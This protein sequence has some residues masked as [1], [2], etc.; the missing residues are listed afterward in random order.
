MIEIEIVCV[1]GQTF[2]FFMSYSEKKDEIIISLE[3]A[4]YDDDDENA[5]TF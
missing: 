3:F 5:F 1:C 2:Q 4:C